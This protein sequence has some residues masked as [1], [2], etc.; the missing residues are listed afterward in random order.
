MKKVKFLLGALLLMVVAVACNDDYDTPPMVVPTA[1]HTPNMTLLEFKTKYWQDGRNFI[2]T[3]KEDIVIHG[4]VSGTDAAGNIYKHMYIQDETAGLGISIDANSIYNTYR[5]GQEVVINMK[6][7]FIGKYNG[8]YLLG[9]P[10]WYAAQSAWEAGRMTL[11]MFQQ[12]AELNGLPNL[13]K[14]VPVVTKI[15]DF[16]G[17]SDGET[18]IKYQGQ[19][20]KFENVKWQEA[21]GEVPYSEASASS[22]RHIVDEE[23]NTLDV[24]NSNYA[25]FRANILPLGTGDVVGILYLTGSDQW[26]LYLRDTD[27]CIGFE[28]NTKGTLKDPYTV[29]EAIEAQDTDAEGW[30]EGYI[31]GAV[32]PEVQTVSGNGDIEFKAPT[33]LDNTLVIGE[34]ADTKDIAQCVVVAL[35]P[36]SSFRNDASLVK[37][38][39]LLGTKILVKGKLAKFMGMAGITEN[40]GSQDEYKLSIITGGVTQ[41]EEGFETGIPST[42]KNIQVKGDKAWYQTTFDNNGYA[43]M[44]GYKGTAPFESW[45]IS[46]AIDIKNA[47]NKTFSFQSQ[48]NGYGSTTTTMKVYLLTTADPETAEKIELTSLAKW[49]TAPASGYSGFVESGDIDLSEYEG[50]YCIGFVYEATNDANYGTWTIDDVKF[51]MG[52]VVSNTESD[53]D[54]MN[55]GKETSSF[56]TLTSKKGWVATNAALLRG[57]ASDAN[58]IFTFIGGSDVYAVNLNGKVGETGVLVSPVI[59][60]GIGTLSFNYGHAL[61]EKGL[62]FIV[63]VKINGVVAKTYTFNEDNTTSKTAY[64][65]NL[66]V[67][68]A[69]NDLTVEVHAQSFTNSTSNK[70]RV[71]IWNVHWTPF[72]P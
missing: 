55:D 43:A 24:T 2:D 48:V 50:T 19:L 17:K 51:G 53:F 36:Q 1:T 57:G 28:N 22:T 67:D 9:K 26:K 25:N 34:T 56:G 4:Y 3:C 68:T 29:L 33:T 42:W 41:L 65:A 49:P 8:E 27:D 37:Y 14:V 11:D 35:P 52:K 5:V 60:G 54:T 6:D 16:S 64:E 23:G 61:S 32:G 21:D 15:T 39:E 7:F 69:G 10:E 62:H 71:A 18:Q 46:P 63:Y 38:P 40:S 58:P 59:T 72:E 70:D 31:V 12:H 47:P 30:V 45:L 13:D 20:V 44:T 66:A